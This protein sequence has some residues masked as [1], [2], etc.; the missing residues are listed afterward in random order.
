VEE[1]IVEE[2]DGVLV[3]T[4]DREGGGGG[5][6]GM[7]GKEG[8]EENTVKLTVKD[9][10]RPAEVVQRPT[11]GVGRGR[12]SE[13]DGAKGEGGGRGGNHGGV[14]G[15]E[16]TG[17]WQTGRGGGSG[18]GEEVFFGNLLAETR[19]KGEGQLIMSKRGKGERGKPRSEGS[20]VGE[21]CGVAKEL[22]KVRAY[23][24]YGRNRGRMG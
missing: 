1:G 6:R 8:G 12:C 17:G 10:G 23:L 7:T 9:G 18:E 14:G 16:V 5:D 11:E 24:E 22:W 3:V 13:G 21:G 2:R 15:T 4:V 20:E 19:G